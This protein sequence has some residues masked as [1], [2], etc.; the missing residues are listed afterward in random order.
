MAAANDS[1][2]WVKLEVQL[3]ARGIVQGA[4]V[5]RS[6]SYEL[7]DA[8]LAAAMRARFEPARRN[9]YY[10]ESRTELVIHFRGPGSTRKGWCGNEHRS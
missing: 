2:G 1:G 8:A 3:N 10:V 6:S 4:R 9:G 5:R 7:E